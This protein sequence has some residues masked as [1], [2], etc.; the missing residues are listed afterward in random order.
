[1]GKDF[2]LVK[3]CFYFLAFV[4]GAE[5]LLVI[6]LAIGCQVYFWEHQVPMCREPLYD[7]MGN[8]MNH[9]IGTIMAYAAGQASYKPT[10]KDKGQDK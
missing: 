4:L 1:M 2:N 7:R 10:D 8:V 9:A 5:V 6:Y 3:A